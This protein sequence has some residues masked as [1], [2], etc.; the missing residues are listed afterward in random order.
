MCILCAV[1]DPPTGVSYKVFGTAD[2]LISWS[3]PS[4]DAL[5]GHR[6]TYYVK[7]LLDGTTRGVLQVNEPSALVN[8]SVGVANGRTHDFVVSYLVCAYIMKCIYSSS[9]NF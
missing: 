6:K 8:A 9:G 2:I 7:I 5:R 1:P 3:T 4:P